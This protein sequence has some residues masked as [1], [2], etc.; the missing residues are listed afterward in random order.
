MTSL[1]TTILI[2]LL[3]GSLILTAGCSSL[4]EEKNINVTPLPA[5]G[6]PAASYRVTL[7]Q[8][9]VQSDYLKMDTDIYNIGEVVEFT[10]TNE[11]PGI[12]DCAGDPP[13]FSVKFQ[14]INGVWATRM[15]TEK[16]N[17]TTKSSLGPGAS[18]QVYRFVTT[19]WDPG[20]Y[21]IVHDCGVEREILIRSLPA[22]T[23]MPSACPAVNASNATLWIKIDPVGDQY[24]ASP[25]TIRGSTNIPAGQELKYTIFSISSPKPTLSINPEGSFTTVVQ[26]GS[27]GI[28]TWSAMGE[29]HAT[30]EFFVGITN[31]ERNVSAIRRFTVLSP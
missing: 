6:I 27:C 15:G 1:S 2:F 20:R 31:A 13:S 5:L 7:H 10:V 29:I 18:T 26:E 17:E 23:P 19:G 28:N 12:L 21:R 16:P 9:V 22:A 11:G 3:A 24:I 14:G 30:G 4:P 8:P 25:F